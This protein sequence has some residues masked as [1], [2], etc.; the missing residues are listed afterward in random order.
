MKGTLTNMQSGTWY[1]MRI[2][3]GDW[4]T[5]YSLHPQSAEDVSVYLN[6]YHDDIQLFPL[7][8]SGKEVEFEIVKDPANE[9][10]NCARLIPL[11]EDGY[12]LIEGTLAICEDIKQK[13]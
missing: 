8:Y 6:N 11:D 13:L 5:Y 12:P 10:L 4:E 1:V 9:K 2:E 3:E 7:Y